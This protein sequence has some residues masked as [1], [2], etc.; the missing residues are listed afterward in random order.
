MPCLPEPSS[1]QTPPSIGEPSA[2]KTPSTSTRVPSVEEMLA[3]G[4]AWPLPITP[5]N[6][7]G[8]ERHN[9][10]RKGQVF[11]RLQVLSDAPAKTVGGRRHWEC[12]C[13]CGTVV[14][15]SGSHLNNGNTRSCGCLCKEET[16]RAVTKHGKSRSRAYTSWAGMLYRCEVSSCTRHDYYGGRG[17]SVCDRWHKF[18]NFYSD[19]GNPPHGYSIDRIDNDLGY[20]PENCRWATQNTQMQNTSM[21]KLSWAAVGHIRTSRDQSQLLARLYC[22]SRR[23]VNLVRSNKSWYDPLYRP[24]SRQ[25]DNTTGA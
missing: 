3:R 10:I 1:T 11:S 12:M 17:I 15:V 24:K 8:R 13:L 7:E 16:K 4:C 9:A 23:T 22:V 20:S 19:M 21:N 6:T 18:E 5:M 14:I 25:N 2:L